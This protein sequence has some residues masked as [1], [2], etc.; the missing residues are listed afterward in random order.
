VDDYDTRSAGIGW[1]TPPKS[2]HGYD[3]DVIA[4]ELQARPGQWKL[5]FEG[6]RTSVANVIRNGNVRQLRPSDGFQV[7]TRNN[8]AATDTEPKSCDMYLRWVKP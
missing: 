7:T 4:T 2:R 6:G 3:W 8:R 1:K 5:I